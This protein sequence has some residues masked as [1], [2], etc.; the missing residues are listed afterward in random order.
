MATPD[1][2]S[3]SIELSEAALDFKTFFTGMPAKD[4]APHEKHEHRSKRV[5]LNQAPGNVSSDLASMVWNGGTNA[6]TSYLAA[7]RAFQLWMPSPRVFL[8]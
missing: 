5:A 7:L 8:E 4:P 3:S 1:I 6:L 2:S